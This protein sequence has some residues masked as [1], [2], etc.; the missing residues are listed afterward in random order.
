MPGLAEVVLDCLRRMNRRTITCQKCNRDSQ[1][2]S[3]LRRRCQ[4]QFSSQR[5]ALR[6]GDLNRTLGE[7]WL[8]PEMRT[9]SGWALQDLARWESPEL[10]VGPGGALAHVGKR[11]DFERRLADR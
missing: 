5:S 10:T 9:S 2:A 8:G 3:G 4:G 11:C 6:E 7:A 1:S